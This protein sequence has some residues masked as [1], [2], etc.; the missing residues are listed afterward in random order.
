MVSNNTQSSGEYLLEMTNINKSFP[1]VKALDN[2]NLK[3]LPHSI[4]ALMGE[5]VAGRS[6]LL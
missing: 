1:G 5:N 6:T 3:V 2:V 4:H